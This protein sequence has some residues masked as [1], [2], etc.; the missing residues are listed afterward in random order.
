M[1]CLSC[2]RV[3]PWIKSPWTVERAKSFVMPFGK[4]RGKTVGELAETPRGAD[5]LRWVAANVSENTGIAARVALGIKAPDDMEV[6]A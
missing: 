5:Y 6:E 2:G 4:F 1:D 3:G